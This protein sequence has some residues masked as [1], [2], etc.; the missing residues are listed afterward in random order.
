[1]RDLLQERIYQQVPDNVY[2]TILGLTHSSGN[3]AN[4][5]TKWF[6]KMYLEGHFPTFD[7]DMYDDAIDLY[8]GY[9][10]HRSKLKPIMD[11]NSPD[12]LLDDI[13]RLQISGYKSRSDLDRIA[14]EGSQQIYKDN[15]FIILKINTY[16]A[17]RKY[18]SNTKWCIATRL[19]PSVFNDYNDNDDTYFVI[20]RKKKD[21]KYACI[22]RVCWDEWDD[23]IFF[24]P[25]KNSDGSEEN[26]DEFF[27]GYNSLP[28][29]L[30]ERIQEHP[31]LY[32]VLPKAF[33]NIPEK[34]VKRAMDKVIDY[35][36]NPQKYIEKN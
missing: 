36:K 16:A 8:Y 3:Q 5:I 19:S 26:M 27:A 9:L 7:E 35:S 13:Y 30:Y 24:V 14:R 20:D 11:Y 29:E 18:G 34:E 12:D 4:A 25:R 32:D 1:M 10:R 22:G 6:C 23:V 28:S 31:E 2:E 17:C 33:P 21:C 15:D